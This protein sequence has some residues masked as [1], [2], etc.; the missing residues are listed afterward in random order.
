[1]KRLLIATDNFLPRW[2]GVARFLSEIIP[3]LSKK[4]MIT[5]LHRSFQANLSNMT[6]SKI[7]RFKTFNFQVNAY[8]PAKPSR[9]VIHQYV[10]QSDLVWAQAIGPIGAA[11]IRSAHRQ[12]KPVAAFIHSYE[13]DLVSKGIGSRHNTKKAVRWL[14]K[15]YAS[16]IYNK[17]DMIM[18][19]S[20][21]VAEIFNWMKIHPDKKIIH[22]WR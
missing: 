16:H 14:V 9:K 18:T 12:R 20:L 22:L 8:N 7:V 13:W 21:E 17:C 19:P 2:D 6:M 15:K 10:K 3:K 4:Y 5:V 11:A 1:M